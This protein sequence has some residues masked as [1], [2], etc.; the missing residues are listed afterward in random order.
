MSNQTLA[1]VHVI[2]DVDAALVLLKE[3]RRR[4]LEMARSPV[5]AVE[6]AEQL[7][8]TRQRIGYHVRQ[9]VE[10][11]LLREKEGERRGAMVEKRYSAT[12]EAY[13]LDPG[14]LGPLAARLGNDADRDSLSELFGAV[15]QVQTDLARVLSEVPSDGRVQTLTLSTEL[16]LL[17]TAQRGAFAEALVA[18]LT[19]AVA[20]HSTPLQTQA[21]EPG[22]GK[23]F[24]LTLTLHP[25]P[26]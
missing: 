3:P 9:L 20:T 5:S 19:H 24:R 4:L 12:A 1:P 23:A 11:G 16:R 2:S 15:H 13:A 6:A 22:E 14:L 8:E 17:D 10:A 21:G 26:Q 7:G 25:T 18:A